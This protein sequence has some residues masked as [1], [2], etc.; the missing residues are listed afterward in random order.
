MNTLILACAIVLLEASLAGALVARET[1]RRT[2]ALVSAVAVALAATIGATALLRIGLDLPRPW[3]DIL[4]GAA[5]LPILVWTALMARLAGRPSRWPSRSRMAVLPAAGLVFQAGLVLLGIG[6]LLSHFLRLDPLYPRALISPVVL[7]GLMAGGVA[8]AV[9]IFRAVLLGLRELARGDKADPVAL[10][11]AGRLLRL[12]IL[13]RLVVIIMSVQVGMIADPIGPMHFLRAL[14]EP[15]LFMARLFLGMML[16]YIAAL[17][18]TD[19]VAREH[20]PDGAL[21]FI[22]IGLLVLMGELIGAGMMVGTWGL[23][24]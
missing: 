3:L 5:M 1:A 19:A 20:A 11:R 12:G 16:P 23:S 21:H 14:M 2:G 22:P 24:L 7:A 4:L 18:A 9:A 13:A 17:L 8:A 10:L 6:L 15:N